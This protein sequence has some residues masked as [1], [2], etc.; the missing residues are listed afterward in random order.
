MDTKYLK[1]SNN[2][3]RPASL[4]VLAARVQDISPELVGVLTSFGENRE[5]NVCSESDIYQIRDVIIQTNNALP[6]G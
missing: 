6:M 5:I 3:I 4:Q 1:S 2:S